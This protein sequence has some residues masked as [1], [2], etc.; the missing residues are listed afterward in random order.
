MH[1]TVKNGKLGCSICAQISHLGTETDKSYHLSK[2]WAN[3]DVRCNGNTKASRQASL[4]KK[5]TEHFMSGSHL[6]CLKIVQQS[7]KQNMRNL[8]TNLMK[9]EVET[10][11]KIFN[12]IYSLVKRNRPMS[13]IDAML[14]LQKIN[15]VEFGSCL[16]SRFTAIRIV[17]H[18]AKEL[19]LN[20]FQKIISENAKMS[21]IIDE[22]STIASKSVL[23]I[24][25]KCELSLCDE[26]VFIFLQLFELFSTNAESIYEAL[27]YCM[28]NNGFS[29]EYL[30]KNLIAFCSDGA[31]VMLGSKSGVATRVLKDFPNI[32]IWHCL[33]HRLQL[34]LDDSISDISEI[35]HFK[36][37]LDKI[38]SIYH[39][40]NKNQYEL[41]AIAEN[42]E[43]E[44]VKIGRVLGP[45]W[46]SCS[47]RT[48][49]AVWRAYPALYFH[50]IANKKYTGLARRLRNKFFLKDLALIID[51]LSEFALL[52]NALQSRETTMHQADKLIRRTINALKQLKNENG[53]YEAMVENLI[54]SE[55]F[56]DIAFEE[57]V[58]FK[59]LPK[60]KLIDSL[61]KYMD[62]RLLKS[63]HINFKKDFERNN[64][65][66]VE[67]LEIFNVLVPNTWDL[68]NI[69]SPWKDGENKLENLC[70]IIKYE[71]DINDFRDFVDMNIESQNLKLPPTIIRAKKI[72]NTI[73]ISSAEAE[74]GFSLM[75]TICSEKRSR[76]TIPHLSDLITIN[77][78]G[79]PIDQWNPEFYV[80]SWLKNHCSA[81][82]VHGNKSEKSVYSE[83]QMKIWKY[84]E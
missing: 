40:S 79:K 58:N 26:P 80:K 57:I 35:N 77:M 82:D 16:Q 62:D 59:S 32:I 28:K 64:L 67:F 12:T 10:T 21:I 19:R 8:L 76:L 48:A 7:E 25:I 11:T 50:F 72:I 33:N 37:F 2:S 68:E 84:V 14:Q 47:L 78:C 34:V 44:I 61:V 31:S 49:L 41:K 4:R 66:S 54:I 83:N 39:Q 17:E 63:T 43:I 56:K 9:K 55:N 60:E 24:F 1:L 23:I 20:L 36:S 74:R 70:K 29:N 3:N 71:V 27:I 45:R 6:K 52:S 65:S 81:I 42:L 69:L 38:Y 15:N 53:K 51:V 46:A 5:M 18:I 22:A 13:D 75:N 73:A 30:S